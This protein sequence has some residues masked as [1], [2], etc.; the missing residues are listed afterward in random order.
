MVYLIMTFT[1]GSRGLHSLLKHIQLTTLLRPLYFNT[2][3]HLLLK[4]LINPQ[5]SFLYSERD[6][7]SQDVGY[8]GLPNCGVS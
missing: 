3:T 4:E 1:V 7:Y 8:S 2:V 6:F 5:N